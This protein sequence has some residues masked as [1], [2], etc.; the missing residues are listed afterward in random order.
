M[1]E[2][3][4]QA[5]KITHRAADIAVS[6]LKKKSLYANKVIAMELLE[7]ELAKRNKG[8]AAGILKNIPTNKQYS[9]DE[10]LKSAF[11]EPED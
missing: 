3:L 1:L 5:L 10:S 4:I 2:M 7:V 11:D 6:S 8:S 9:G